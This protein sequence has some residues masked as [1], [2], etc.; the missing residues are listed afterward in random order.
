MELRPQPRQRMRD[1]SRFHLWIVQSHGACVGVLGY[2]V[3][4]YPFTLW[5]HAEDLKKSSE[6]RRLRTRNR[7]RI[8]GC[9]P[10]FCDPLKECYGLGDGM[11]R[12]DHHIGI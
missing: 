8:H 3:G 6:M 2:R 4:G 10:L 1:P 11:D 9:L 7:V 12:V 5:K